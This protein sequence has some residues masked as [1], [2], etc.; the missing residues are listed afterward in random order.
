MIYE[1]HV[2]TFTPEGTWAAAAREL[3]ALARLGIT[4]IEMM[5]IAEFPGRFGWG[6]DGVDLF[7]PAH[8]YGTPGRT[9]RVRRS[10][11]RPRPRR[12]ARRRLQ[13]PRPGRQLSARILRRLFHRQVRERLGA[14][15]RLRGPDRRRASSS[16]RT[17][18]YWIDEFHLD[19]LRLD[20]TQDIHDASPRHVIAEIVEAR[21]RRSRE[22]VAS[23]SSPRTNR[24]TPQSCVAGPAASESDALWNDDC[25]S[26]GDRGA[27][28]TPRGVLL[29]TTR[30]RRRSSSRARGSATSFRDSGTRGRRRD[31]GRRRSICR[32]R[33]SS[34]TSRTTIRSRIRHTA[35]GC[36]S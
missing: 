22:P 3:D 10:R 36:I 16:S 2:G 4:V 1:M 15:D 23:S 18:R 14:S 25:A 32:R 17:P 34:R 7:A 20:A 11:A 13:P 29:A 27:D 31:A 12:D 5:P 26:L 24:R 33:D 19:G 28:R 35:D 30:A 6:Y 9:P 21:A 8:V